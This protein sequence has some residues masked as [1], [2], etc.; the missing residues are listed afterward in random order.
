M[1]R[2]VIADRI[3]SHLL[4]QGKRAV[5]RDG[6][7]RYR[8]ESGLSCAIG[9]LILDEC[10][11]AA[12]EGDGINNDEVQEVLAFSLGLRGFSHSEIDFLHAFQKIH[13]NSAHPVSSWLARLADRYLR[14]KLDTHLLRMWCAFGKL[15]E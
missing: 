2:Q 8:T 4:H 11:T 3:A 9:G 10:Y 12:I 14:Y 7:C 13:D 15:P 5:T 6:A 1:D